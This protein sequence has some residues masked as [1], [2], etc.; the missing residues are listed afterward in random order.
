MRAALK[1]RLDRVEKAMP[2]PATAA[3]PSVV[4]QIERWL[5]DTGI[6]RRGEESVAETT[7]RAMGNNPQE[8]R[9]RLCLLA[10]GGGPK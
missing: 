9:R 3:C 2:K 4:P 8:L 10:Y 6:V 7:A 1:H 5:A